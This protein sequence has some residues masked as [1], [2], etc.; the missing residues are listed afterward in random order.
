M[1]Y[2]PAWEL[3]KVHPPTVT[4]VAPSIPGPNAQHLGGIIHF[5]MALWGVKLGQACQ[6]VLVVV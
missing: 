2:Y 5:Q 1:T 4:K 6:P 3:S